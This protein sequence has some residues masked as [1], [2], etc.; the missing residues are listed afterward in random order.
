MRALA[1]AAEASPGDETEPGDAESEVAA[2][3]GLV[4]LAT[5]FVEGLAGRC[6]WVIGFAPCDQ[7]LGGGAF[8]QN[9]EGS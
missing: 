5:L 8:L 7:A 2:L 6:R 3:D 9:S 1:T 4:E